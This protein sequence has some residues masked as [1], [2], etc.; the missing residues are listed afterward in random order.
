MFDQLALMMVVMWPFV[1]LFLI[2]LHFAVDFWRRL[3]AWSYLI[4]FLQWIPIGILYYKLDY[5]LP[6]L[7]LGV[8]AVSAGVAL[9]SWTA[10]LIGIKATVG[11]TEMKPVSQSQSDNQDLITSGPFSFVRH[12]S[13]WVHTSIIVGV[14]LITGVVSVGVIAI[15]DLAI[16]YFVTTE[17][18]DKELVERFGNRYR[19]YQKRVP[20]FFPKLKKKCRLF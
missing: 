13:Y 11:Y 7:V 4:V 19:E 15:I 2:E 20:K 16:T 9:H 5:F 12:P 14:F 17:L 18:E 6:F 1:P 8:I 3:G 10:E